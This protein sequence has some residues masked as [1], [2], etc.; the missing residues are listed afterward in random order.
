[1]TGPSPQPGLAAVLTVI[2]EA[3]FPSA[4]AYLFW[5]RGVEAAGANMAGHFVRLMPVVLPGE[6]AGWLHATGVPLVGGIGSTS[7]YR[8]QRDQVAV[9]TSM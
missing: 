8:H 3:V 6:E 1:L 9:A 7:L 5:N 2:C 4:L